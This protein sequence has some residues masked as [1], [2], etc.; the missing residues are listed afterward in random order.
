[1]ID[2]ARAGVE[3]HG[4]LVL[5]EKLS[6]VRRFRGVDLEDVE[7]A[8]L[9]ACVQ[10]VRERGVNVR[11]D[12]ALEA[13]IAVELHPNYGPYAPHPDDHRVCHT[14]DYQFVIASH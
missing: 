14:S 11:Q 4:D 12:Y 6:Q 2:L 3:R 10:G 8:L 7:A 1:M 13:V 9:C 5:L